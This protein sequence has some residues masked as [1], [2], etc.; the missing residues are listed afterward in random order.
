MCTKK[1]IIIGTIIALPVI[2][3]FSM[4]FVNKLQ[5]EKQYAEDLAVQYDETMKVTYRMLTVTTSALYRKAEILEQNATKAYKNYPFDYLEAFKYL[6]EQSFKTNNGACIIQD[7]E[8]Y[9]WSRVSLAVGIL[10]CGGNLRK[11]ESQAVLKIE[12]AYQDLYNPYDMNYAELI[13][14][15]HNV[16]KS[17][18]ESLAEL[19]KYQANSVGFDD[20][21]FID[22]WKYR[23]IFQRYE[24]RKNWPF[25]FL[26]R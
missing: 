20:W 6:N 18:S 22:D 11:K 5:N 24:S 10:Q 19:A 7:I 2:V 1:K 9:Y 16:K 8:Y 14:C 12:F 23:D 13:D 3:L 26:N 17:L 4:W 15:L 21:R 25:T